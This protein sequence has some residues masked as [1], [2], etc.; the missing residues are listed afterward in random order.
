MASLPF[1]STD[2][3]VAEATCCSVRLAV[4]RLTIMAICCRAAGRSPANRGSDT[5]RP[6]SARL[7]RPTT[8]KTTRALTTNSAR[9]ESCETIRL[10]TITGIKTISA[11][12]IR[13]R[14]F[15]SLSLV[16]LATFSNLEAALPKPTKGCQRLA[17]PIK[18][19]ISRPSSS[20][21][22]VTG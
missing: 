19:S 15:P 22:A 14:N 2:S 21:T 3:Q 1:S 16:G 7:L 18:W 11:Q 4:S 10:I 13:P 6:C 20:A 5:L 9:P 17:S 8:K 12:Q